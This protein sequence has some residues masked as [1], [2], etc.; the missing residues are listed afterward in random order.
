MLKLL[1]RLFARERQT[2]EGVQWSEG[3]RPLVWTFEGES[4]RWR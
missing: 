3:A 2:S 1:K 4:L